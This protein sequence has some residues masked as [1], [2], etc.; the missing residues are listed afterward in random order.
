MVSITFVYRPLSMCN[1]GGS[2]YV[3]VIYQRRVCQWSLHCRLTASEWDEKAQQVVFPH[4]NVLRQE[5]LRG[6][7]DK[8]MRHAAVLRIVVSELEC[9]GK[10]FSVREIQ[11]A[12]ICRENGQS[13]QG[14]TGRLS[15][16]MERSG[17]HRM[18]RAYHGATETLVRFAGK[19]LLFD[20]I[21]PALIKSFESSLKNGGCQANTIAFYFRVIRSIC[22][23][24]WHEG[25]MNRPATEL[26]SDVF[27]GCAITPKRAL[28]NEDLCRIFG[29]DLLSQM[30]R[31]DP[32]CRTYQR[33]KGLYQAWRLFY[34]SFNACGMCFVD[35]AYLRKDCISGDQLIYRR[36]KTGQ[37]IDITL[38]APLQIIINSFEQ[39]TEGSPYVF[40]LLREPDGAL[41]R[42]YETAARSYNRRLKQLGALAGIEGCLTSHTARH[43]WASIGKN[44]LFPLA[45]LS[46]CLGHSSEKTTRIYLASFDR[47]ILAEANR[48]ITEDFNCFSLFGKYKLPPTDE[49]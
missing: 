19:N 17:R 28:K 8:L 30:E 9:S 37:L 44:K 27:T 32:A 33:L 26:F 10:D 40:P 42:Q 14:Y 31:E 15:T 47:T 22:N 4:D 25:R 49:K 11:A 16:E 3:R 6:V 20:D 7:S 21:N 12:Y 45:V 2:L 5:Y 41:Y 39:E 29:Y 35:L 46:A 23:K 13:L 48:I 18:A 24:A 1:S 34:F 38:T 36:K 43:S